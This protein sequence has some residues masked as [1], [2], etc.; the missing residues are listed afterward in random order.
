MNSLQSKYLKEMVIN[1]S[2]ALFIYSSI[3]V[4]PILKECRN[5]TFEDEVS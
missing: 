5:K 3:F 4:K 2:D 1:A